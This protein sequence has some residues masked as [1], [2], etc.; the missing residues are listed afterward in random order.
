MGQVSGAAFNPAVAVG[1]AIVGQLPW[2]SLWLY[3]V[4]ELLAAAAAALAFRA[5]DPGAVA[6]AALVPPK[7]GE[8]APAR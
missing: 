5:L 1:A 6:E 8:P 3:L 7:P 2:S 4:P